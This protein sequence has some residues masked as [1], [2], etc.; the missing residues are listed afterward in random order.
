MQEQDHFTPAVREVI[1]VAQRE[2]VRMDAKE[3]SPEHL[4]LGVL[5]QESDE[6]AEVFSSLRLNQAALREQEA[7]LFPSHS[8]TGE[9]D[10]RSV[11][12]SLEAQ[13]CLDWA[14]SFAMYQHIPSI[15]PEHLLL[16]SVRHQ[17]LQ[18][19]LALFLINAGSTLPSYLTERSER[20]YTA[21]MD[22]RIFSRIRRWG[23]HGVSKR[24]QFERPTSLFSDILGFHGVKQD[25]REV[26][27]FLRNPQLVQQDAY[28]SLYG[29]L[30]V[31]PAGNS[32]TLI[33]HAIAGEAGIPLLSL[34]LSA[35]VERAHTSSSDS[36]EDFDVVRSPRE[37]NQ[38]ERE[39]MAERGRH[40]I[41]D[42]FEQG[43]RTSPCVLCID[44]LD[45]LAR[46]EVRDIRE[47]WQGQ[48]RSEM[49]GCNEHMAVVAMVSRREQIDPSLV[50][51]GR[52]DHTAILDGTVMRPFEVG[53]VLCTSCQQQIPTQW[54]YCGFCGEAAADT[55]P[56]C[57]AI[58]PE[59]KGVHFCPHCGEKLE[60]K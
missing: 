29:L 11:P 27:D 39:T 19:L 52:F 55:C 40:I 46:P 34:S 21:T 20:V 24:I 22:Q 43:K 8:D 42:L 53:L 2:A 25:L 30:L 49:D 54:E 59:V 7:T 4:F 32:R 3:V 33:G 51:A 35:L 16:G 31:G 50:V 15:Q 1:S 12:L 57:G 45:V 44:E 14:I 28:A 47:Q 18:P 6:V 48:L 13:A 60:E 41:R 56:Q 38:T 36:V 37:S 10:I 9:G 58:R 17:R 26:L 23:M 5:A